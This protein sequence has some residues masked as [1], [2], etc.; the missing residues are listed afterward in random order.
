M[1]PST[2]FFFSVVLCGLGACGAP[3]ES[4]V[5]TVTGDGAL[6]VQIANVRNSTGSLTCSLFNS[7]AGFPGPSR[8]A[9][10]T[11]QMPARAGAMSCTFRNLPAGDYAVSV[12]HDENNNRELDTNL[13]GAPLEG[14]GATLNNLPPAATPTW[15]NN[16][17][18]IAATQTVSLTLQLRY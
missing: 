14:Y 11:L 4:P 1:K 18:R 8:I 6:Q 9:G 3:D 12:F 15:D 2:I 17:V 7:A 5:M 13:L 16:H 10:G